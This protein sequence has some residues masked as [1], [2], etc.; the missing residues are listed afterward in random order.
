MFLTEDTKRKKRPRIPLSANSKKK[1]TRVFL[2]L[3]LKGRRPRR[4][5]S[6]RVHPARAPTTRAR[7]QNSGNLPPALVFFLKVCLKV[8]C[9]KTKKGVVRSRSDTKLACVAKVELCK[10]VFYS[11]PK[12]PK[13]QE[14]KR[15]KKKRSFS[16]KKK[17]KKTKKKADTFSHFEGGPFC[18]VIKNEE[19][20]FEERKEDTRTT[21]TTTFFATRETRAAVDVGTREAFWHRESARGWTFRGARA[22][23]REGFRNAF[24]V[25]CLRFF[26]V[27]RRD[28]LGGTASTLEYI[29]NSTLA[30]K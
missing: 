2:S 28:K 18:A 6:K 20:L 26:S 12:H 29:C 7:P 27:T 10:H 4:V 21:T 8:L 22:T 14:K 9:W 25:L 16:S 23:R 17:N 11:S 5:T 1:N 15:E 3:A 13:Q 24:F 30:A 19:T